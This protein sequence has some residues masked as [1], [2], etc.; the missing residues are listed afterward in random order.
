MSASYDALL[1]D[2]TVHVFAFGENSTSGWKNYFQKSLLTIYPPS[3]TFIQEAPNG[4]AL[5]V[6]TPFF[7]KTNFPHNSS[8]NKNSISI[9]DNSGPH[10]VNIRTAPTLA[11]RALIESGISARILLPGSKRLVQLSDK[12]TAKSLDTFYERSLGSYDDH[13]SQHC[14]TECVKVEEIDH[15]GIKVCTEYR[16]VCQHIRVHAVLVVRVGRPQDIA[17]AVENAL[18]KAAIAS[19]IAAFLAAFA[20]GGS[21]AAASAKATFVAVLTSEL[22]KNV[23]DLLVV[24]IDFRTEWV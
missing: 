4:V 20:T 9:T 7:A 15:T 8:D 22:S 24:D 3:F 13:L 12:L 10:T 11:E 19:A 17:N 5:Q 21:G 16:T 2:D 6:I 14:A 23:S 1:V 18:Q